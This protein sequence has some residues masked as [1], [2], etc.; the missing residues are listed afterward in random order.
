VNINHYAMLK[1]LGVFAAVVE[2]G[3][4]TAAAEALGTAQP[5]VSVQVQQLEQSLGVPLLL[6]E[7]RVMRL[8]SEGEAI[9]PLAQKMMAALGDVIATARDFA[10]QANILRFETEQSAIHDPVKN[11]LIA[12]FVTRHQDFPL[13]TSQNRADPIVERLV[14]REIDIAYSW[15]LPVNDERI[16]KLHMVRHEIS[17]LVPVTHSLARN[18]IIAP[19]MLG[20]HQILVGRMESLTQTYAR[21]R[22]TFDPFEVRWVVPPDPDH[23]CRLQMVQM[24]GTPSLWL[25]HLHAGSLPGDVVVRRIVGAPVFMDQILMRLA[26]RRSKAVELFWQLAAT[27]KAEADRDRRPIGER[28]VQAVAEGLAL[29]RVY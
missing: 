26:G 19:A 23:A 25:D 12:E 4:F 10:D 16:E 6:R 22:R 20:G 17:L 8:T 13:V 1:K 27:L 28:P 11:R 5:W 9:F 2:R 14:A 21:L 3:S 15:D 18:E 29:Q 7:S 24:L